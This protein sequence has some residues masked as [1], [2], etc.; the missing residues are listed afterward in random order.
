MARGRRDIAYVFSHVLLCRRPPSQQR[1]NP[2]LRVGIEQGTSVV[3]TTELDVIVGSVPTLG[4]RDSRRLD[5]LDPGDFKCIVIDE[6]HHAAAATY[7]RILT[8]FGAHVSTTH[9]LVRAFLYVELSHW[10]FLFVFSFVHCSFLFFSFL[11]NRC[12]AVLRR[13]GDTTGCHL[14]AFSTKLDI[15]AI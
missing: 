12:G 13:C 7:T 6:A 2:T 5:R 10:F 9:V 8:H 14:R 11:E 15:R 1:I 3:N 4:M